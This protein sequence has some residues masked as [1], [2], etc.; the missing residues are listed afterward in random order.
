MSGLIDFVRFANGEQYF[1]ED[2]GRVVLGSSMSAP[3]NGV[4][5]VHPVRNLGR[6]QHRKL[7]N[8]LQKW[9]PVIVEALSTDEWRRRS[10]VQSW[11]ILEE[12]CGIQDPRMLPPASVEV[13]F[14]AAT[15]L[16]CGW[17]RC[18][19]HRDGRHVHSWKVPGMPSRPRAKNTKIDFELAEKARRIREEAGKSYRVIAEMINV[20]ESAVARII[21]RETH[22]RDKKNDDE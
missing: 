17:V 5:N 14:I 7:V 13:K 11:D 18:R 16:E 3:E 19:G 12:I 15:L 20:S 9:K 21:R 1:P 6:E 4:I 22:T 2:V 10:S 8:K